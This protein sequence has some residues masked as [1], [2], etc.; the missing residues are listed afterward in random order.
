MDLHSIIKQISHWD[1]SFPEHGIATV[2]DNEATSK[3]LLR[4]VLQDAIKNYKNIPEGYVGHLYALYILAFFR[5]VESYVPALQILS[6]PEQY[7]D[8]LLGHFLTQSYSQVIASCYDGNLEPLLAIIE[9][10]KA[11]SLYRIVALVALSIL[12][13]TKRV[14]RET[15]VALFTRL[16]EHSTDNEFLL[17]VAEEIADLHL[18]E[19]KISVVKLYQDGRIHSD[20]Y[21]RQDFLAALNS[22]YSNPRKFF[23]IEDVFF[24][25]NGSECSGS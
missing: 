14:A 6:L 19:L 20:L 8:K 23:L 2:V 12:Y 3:P 5:D 10:Q 25:L 24:E 15:I 11:P 4:A 17:G 7:P 9:N 21:G 22:G 1:G 18:Q 13:N 16:L